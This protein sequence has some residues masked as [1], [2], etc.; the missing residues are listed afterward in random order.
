VPLSSQNKKDLIKPMTE[1][2]TSKDHLDRIRIAFIHMKEILLERFT[3]DN[4]TIMTNHSEL[5]E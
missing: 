3:N 5:R 2:L 4:S 1:K